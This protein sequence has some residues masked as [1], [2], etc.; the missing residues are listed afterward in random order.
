[1]REDEGMPKG[2]SLGN[3]KVVIMKDKHGP[4]TDKKVKNIK[5]RAEARNKK[6]FVADMDEYYE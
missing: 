5:S 2:K 6:N 3:K 4:I 1:M